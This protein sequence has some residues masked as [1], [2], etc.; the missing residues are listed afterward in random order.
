MPRWRKAVKTESGTLGNLLID[1]RDVFSREKYEERLDYQL[2]ILTQ[3]FHKNKTVDKS[4][5]KKVVEEFIKDV[6]IILRELEDAKRK[7]EQ[8]ESSKIDKIKQLLAEGA[9]VN[10]GKFKKELGKFGEQ[11]KSNTVSAFPVDRPPGPSV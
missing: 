4:Q 8:E 6:E 7:A 10:S 11:L 2:A 1:A 9:K 5:V 3:L